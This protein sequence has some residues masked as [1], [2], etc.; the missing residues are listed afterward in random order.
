MTKHKKHHRNN[1]EVQDNPFNFNINSIT[2]VIKNINVEQL[3]SILNNDDNKN[4]EEE[5]RNKQ[6]IVNAIKLLINTDKTEL[7]G[8]LI[9]LYGASKNN[10]EK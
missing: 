5:K 4:S 3:D 7:L 10:K 8:I 2:D 9:E 6:E 1:Y